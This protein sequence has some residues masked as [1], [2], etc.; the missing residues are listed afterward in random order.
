[1]ALDDLQSQPIYAKRLYSSIKLYFSDR[2]S[3]TLYVS[4]DPSLYARLAS[5]GDGASPRR[6]DGRS[7][8]KEDDKT[9]NGSPGSHAREGQSTTEVKGARNVDV[10]VLEVS[11]HP[12]LPAIVVPRRN[13][14]GGVKPFT[15]E[16]CA[17]LAHVADVQDCGEGVREVEDQK[18][19]DNARDTVQVGDGGGDDE[20]DNPVDRTQGEPQVAALLGGDGGEVEDLLED[21]NVDSLHA[22]VE[23]HD[24]EN[25]DG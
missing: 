15:G 11:A 3:V 9:L 1:M 16:L 23:V 19:S 8:T 14:R 20:G 17:H 13:T 25:R 5:D 12:S 18:S 24:L 10:P 2:S 6:G 4:T 22:N 21:F 7:S